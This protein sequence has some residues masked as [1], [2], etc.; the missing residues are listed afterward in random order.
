MRKSA[1]GITLIAVLFMVAPAS[2]GIVSGQVVGLD[3]RLIDDNTVSITV[4]TTRDGRLLNSTTTTTGKFSITIN[5]DL[6]SPVDK[7]VTVFFTAPGRDDATIRQLLGTA[8]IVLAVVQPVGRP[9]IHG[10]EPCPTY[11]RPRWFRRCW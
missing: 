5:D 8:S 4:R 3:G 9:G 11:C 10:A 1:L 6:L 7:D 2:A